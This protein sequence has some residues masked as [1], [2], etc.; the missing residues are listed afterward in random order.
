[1]IFGVVDTLKPFH[2]PVHLAAVLFLLQGLALVILLFASAESDVNLGAALVVNEQ[3][4]RDNGE[5]R[6]LGVL[7]QMVY[8][9]LIEKQLAVALSLVVV[10]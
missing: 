9:T 4:G 1:M 8:L 2:G 6:R 10:V 3:E 7:K 5:A